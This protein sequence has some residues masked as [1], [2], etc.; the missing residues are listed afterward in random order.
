MGILLPIRHIPAGILFRHSLQILLLK[1]L[2]VRIVRKSLKMPIPFFHS[3]RQPDNTKHNHEGL[4]FPDA[5][6][7][8]HRYKNDKKGCCLYYIVY[9]QTS[10][11]Q[12]CL[13]NI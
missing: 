12:F 13:S 9:S 4:P 6:N 11:T 3:I 1:A 8:I 5:L 7:T 2:P 10:Q